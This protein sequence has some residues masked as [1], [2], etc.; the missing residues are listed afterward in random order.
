MCIAPLSLPPPSPEL[1]PRYPPNVLATHSGGGV[2]RLIPLLATAFIRPSPPCPL[3]PCCRAQAAIRGA[4]LDDASGA[5]RS[6]LDEAAATAYQVC[7][8]GVQVIGLP[9]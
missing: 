8:G 5:L 7:V 6:F 2:P 1:A 3:T 4:I 9:R